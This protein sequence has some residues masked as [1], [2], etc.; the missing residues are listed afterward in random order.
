M[1]I[2]AR[3]RTG[4]EARGLSV[5]AVAAA[6]RVQPRF[7]S[8]IE[9]NDWRTM[10]PAYGRGFVR[11]YAAYVGENPDRLCANY[12]AQVRTAPALPSDAPPREPSRVLATA[13]SR[14]CP[15]SR[16][17][18]SDRAIG[19]LALFAALQAGGPEVAPTG[20]SVP[21]VPLLPMATGQAERCPRTQ[22]RTT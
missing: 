11:A 3:L 19:G 7:I 1:N 16:R 10:P 6:L 18:R 8:A 20:V 12:F 17:C 14:T 2:G 9:E 15:R 21:S 13:P 22:A 5:T 4:R